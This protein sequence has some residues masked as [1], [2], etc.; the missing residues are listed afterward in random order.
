MEDKKVFSSYPKLVNLAWQGTFLFLYFVR[1]KEKED[2][3]LFSILTIQW[4][5]IHVQINFPSWNNNTEPIFFYFSQIRAKHTT[6]V[7]KKLQYQV[8]CSKYSFQCN[9]VENTH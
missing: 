2:K 3:D 9:N 8:F 6:Y 1:S 5:K 4:E 7:R